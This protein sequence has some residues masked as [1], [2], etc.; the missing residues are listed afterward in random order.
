MRCSFPHLFK[1]ISIGNMVLKNR[2]VVP[3]IGTIFSGTDAHFDKRLSPYLNERA[4]GGFG[5]I[6]VEGVAVDPRGRGSSKQVGFWD[7]SFIPE[8]KEAVNGV[9][10]NGSKAALQLMHAGRNTRPDAIFG[11]QPIGPSAVADPVI[12]YLPGEITTEEIKAVVE[13]FAAAAR[14]AKEAGFD[15]V[16]IHG[17]H[18]YL[19]SQFMSGYANKRRDEYG[20]DFNGFIKFPVEIIKKT[21]AAVG[22]DYPIIFRISSDE[23]VPGGRSLDGTVKMVKCLVDAGIDA[24]HVS[25]GVYETSFLTMAPADMDQGYNIKGA[26]AVKS[27]VSV[28]VIAVGRIHDP[29]LAEEV[30]A[31]GKADLV[32]VGR[33]SLADPLWGIKTAQNRTDQIVKCLSCLECLSLAWRGNPIKCVQNPVLGRERE[34][35]SLSPSVVRRI[36]IAGGG[37]AGLEAARTAAVLGH[38]VI[39]CEK[40]TKL[41]GQINAAAVLPKKDLLKNVVSSRVKEL[42]RLNVDI[43][44]GKELDASAVNNIKPDVLV[45]ATGST[46]CMPE[47]PGIDRANPLT[48]AEA[49]AGELAGNDILIIGGGAVGC[50]IAEYFADQ[51]KHVTIVEVLGKVA[52][53]M[54]PPQRH[55]LLNRLNEKN[56]HI[57]TSTK[58][59]EIGTDDVTIRSVDGV[60]K[61]GP[62][63]HIVVAAG[64]VSVN[65]LTTELHD[66]VP[67]ICIIGDARDP[68]NIFNAVQEAYEV[69][70]F[71]KKSGS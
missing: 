56:V 65:R 59:M 12:R 46:G 31:S 63:N 42:E 14:R 25:M 58:I 57:L 53:G 1:P 26:S 61:I 47:I 3:P 20:R 29:F 9:H 60:K 35:E 21:R 24:I 48:A 49:L 19:I 36:L 54:M 22:Q 5:L 71:L 64:A 43:R 51:E 37:P 50:E 6:I 68:G 40:E 41:G 44:L 33:Q 28:P 55:F 17:G 38:H 32:A 34:H 15:A 45:I 11:R 16:E 27:A 8:L 18:G 52:R 69:I 13:A 30:I 4:K 67:E 62:F 7:D 70:R 39:L 10:E 2:L 66:A 23:G